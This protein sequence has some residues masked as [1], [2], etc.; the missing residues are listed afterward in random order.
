[1]ISIQ[2]LKVP[3]VYLKFEIQ[4]DY[5][6]ENLCENKE[7]PESLCGGH[8]YLQ[9]QLEIVENEQDN[10]SDHSPTRKIVI[11]EEFFI[12]ND[13][14]ITT[15]YFFEYENN[16]FEYSISYFFENVIDVFHPP[17]FL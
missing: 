12:W 11:E 1:M 15:D 2:L 16:K 9:K 7:N 5:I 8:C 10:S 6:V 13:F 17:S 14:Q 3:F 4:E